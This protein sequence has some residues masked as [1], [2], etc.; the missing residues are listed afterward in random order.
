MSQKQKEKVKK[1]LNAYLF[2]V[3]YGYAPKEGK[4]QC[5][6]KGMFSKEDKVWED[7]FSANKKGKEYYREWTEKFGNLRVQ[8]NLLPINK[9]NTGK[10][11]LSKKGTY[12][13]SENKKS[14]RMKL[15]AE[16]EKWLKI[17]KKSP[18]LGLANFDDVV[19]EILA[20]VHKIDKEPPESVKRLPY[21]L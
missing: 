16:I 7:P 10:N 2:N 18:K 15:K 3:E 19:R 21:V 14:L 8:T 1:A 20:L 6:K 17:R 12:S 11:M 9:P 4:D 13:D 5:K